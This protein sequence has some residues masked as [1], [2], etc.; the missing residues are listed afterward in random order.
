M[1]YKLNMSGIEVQITQ[2]GETA[3]LVC[4]I[5]TRIHNCIVI[6]TPGIPDQS[7]YREIFMF[8]G[9][10][11]E[12]YYTA[13][14]IPNQPESLDDY[15]AN[16]RSIYGQNTIHAIMGFLCSMN[17]EYIKLLLSMTYKPYTDELIAKLR[18][19]V[20]QYSINEAK[21]IIGYGG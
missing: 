4:D 6:K 21:Y 2:Y 11:D 15:V 1:Y 18:G 16:S 20:E 5:I 9:G 7:V 12:L 19:P 13:F 10:F 17:P 3:K 14:P 8:V